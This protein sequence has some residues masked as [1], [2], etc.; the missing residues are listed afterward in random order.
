MSWGVLPWT[1]PVWESLSFLD[2]GDYFLPCFRDVFNYYLLK[3]FLMVFLLALFFWDS[4]DSNVR[5]FNIVPE[6]SEVSSFLL[7]LF[8]SFFF[9]LC[10]IYFYH[11]IFYLS[12]PIFCLCYSTVGSLQSVFD[13][14]YCIFI[15]ERLFF[16]SSRSLLNIYCIFSILISRLF[17]CNSILFSKFRN[18]FTI[19]V[20]NYFSDR[21]PISSSFVWFGGH[22]HFP[23]PAE[24]FSAFS[25]CLDFYVWGGLSVLWQF[26]IL[27]YCGDSS[28]WVGSDE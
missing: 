11:S 14:I 13:L 1:Y 4:Y 12:Y 9:T 2:L 8:F 22:F 6:V 26:V 28:L 21:F 24:Y 10:F 15:I 19:I 20:L 3:Y 18:T 7:I 27:L 17:I 5:M 16:I 25:S 23:L